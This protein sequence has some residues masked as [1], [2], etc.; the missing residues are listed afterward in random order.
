MQRLTPTK[1]LK[2]KKLP[3]V[4]LMHNGKKN[5]KLVVEYSLKYL[6]LKYQRI[7]I[8]YKVRSLNYSNKYSIGTSVIY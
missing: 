7:E 6:I 1:S 2:K 3:T 8:E 5:F 4:I